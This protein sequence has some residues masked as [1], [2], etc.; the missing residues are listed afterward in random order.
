M[1]G[2]RTIKVKVAYTTVWL[3]SIK[4]EAYPLIS[5]GYSTSSGMER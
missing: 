5:N 3:K 1:N 2:L 4:F